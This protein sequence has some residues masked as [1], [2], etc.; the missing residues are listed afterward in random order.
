MNNVVNFKFGTLEKYNALLQKDNDTLYFADGQIFKGDKVYSQKFEKVGVLPESP[1]QGII[2]VLPDFSAKIWTGADYVDI[3]VGTVG[4]IEN[5]AD[6]DA[7]VATQAAIKAYVTKMTAGMGT[8]ESVQ[9]KIDEA[10]EEA[11]TSATTTAAA[12][13]TNKV[14]AAKKELQQEIDAKVAS[15]F[16]FKGTKD[17]FDEVE[18]IEGMA[19]GDVWHVSA[20]GKE[21]VYTGTEWE[22]LGFTV[23]LSSYATTAEVTKA[24]NDKFEEITETLKGYYTKDQVDAKVTQLTQDIATAKQEAITE[25]E[26]DAQAKADKALSDAKAYADGLNGAMDT[27]VKATEAALTWAEIA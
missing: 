9:A 23:D 2:Y 6:N 8:M 27:R 22:L 17:T 4:E 26:K 25:A 15:V 1:S 14:D 18:A 11:I 10:K 24:I 12:D 20:D 5:S 21:Y 7:K 13:A 16:K 19:T 3:A